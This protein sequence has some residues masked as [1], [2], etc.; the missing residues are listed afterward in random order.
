MELLP[1]IVFRIRVRGEVARLEYVSPATRTIVGYTPDEV[2]AVPDPFEL[3]HPDDH[4]A[5]LKVATG[6]TATVRF[7]HADGR[8][9]ALECRARVERVDN[10]EVLLVGIAIDVTSVRLTEEKLKYQ[11]E[12][13]GLTGLANR[14]TFFHELTNA[15]E[16]GLRVVAVL[17]LDLDRFKKVNDSMGHAAGDQLLAAVAERLSRSIRPHDLLARFGGDE[18]TVLLTDLAGEADAVAVAER[19]RRGLSEPIVVEGRLTAV[20]ASI[21]VAVGDGG[22]SPA[23]LL[24]FSDAAMACAKEEGRNQVRVF[25]DQ[26]HAQLIERIELENALRLAAQ[27]GEIF[28]VFQTEHNLS[29]GAIVGAEVLMRWRLP[30]GEVIRPARFLSA[31]DEIGLLPELDRQVRFKAL[32]EV[33]RLL[34]AGVLPPEFVVRMNLSAGDFVESARPS[35]WQAVLAAA[36]VPVSMVCLEI[37]EASLGL[38]VDELATFVG[39]LRSAGLKV[40]VDDFGT[41]YSSLA[42]LEALPISDVK[43]DRRF[44]QRLGTSGPGRSVVRSIVQLCQALG[45]SVV[46]E[47]VELDIEREVLVELGVTQGQGYLF[48]EPVSI[49]QLEEVVRL[50]VARGRVFVE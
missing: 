40:A 46:A 1:E 13:D 34:R 37:T 28:P 6:S 32:E 12:H 9:V 36:G 35:A 20:N 2:L 47:G 21:G 19:L 39:E 31:A 44:V 4:S 38:D 8:W 29:T 23:D 22:T 48:G 41:G 49:E 45:L 3:M 15:L 50:D 11:A 5:G 26:L 43:I 24:R 27:S 42:Y 7:R 33:G 10:D 16:G 18:F 17:F 25:D 30:S 14:T